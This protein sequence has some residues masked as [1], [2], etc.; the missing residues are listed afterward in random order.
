MVNVNDTTHYA[1]VED[2]FSPTFNVNQL[3]KFLVFV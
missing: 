3:T 2:F 1:P